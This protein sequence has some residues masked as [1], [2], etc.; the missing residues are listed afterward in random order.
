MWRS[1]TNGFSGGWGSG[2]SGPSDNGAYGGEGAGVVGIASTANSKGLA[3]LLF[4]PGKRPDAQALAELGERTGA[5][6]VTHRDPA[7]P[8]WIEVLRDGLTFDIAGLSP[9]QPVQIERSLDHAIGLPN[10]LDLTTLEAIGI[11]PGPHLA[12]AEHLLPVVRVA[13]ALIAVM[14]QIPDAVAVSWLPAGSAVSPIWFKQAVDAWV[15]GGPFPAM[16]LTGLAR[17]PSKMA[18]EGLAF[19]ID[20]EFTLYASDRKLQERDVR[21]AVRLVDWLVAH[22]PVE[23]PREVV[24]SGVGPVWLEPDREGMVHARCL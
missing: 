8:G 19:L 21:V 14:A 16:A 23:E 12:G 7:S 1:A 9:D 11:R 4:A 20:Q 17:T 22:G 13:A 5:F 3:A 6:T 2:Q 15:Q 18:S 24:L 10:G